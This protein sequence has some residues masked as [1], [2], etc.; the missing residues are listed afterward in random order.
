MNSL[1]GK[2][3]TQKQ[4]LLSI[5]FQ[6]QL[7]KKNDLAT[8]LNPFRVKKNPKIQVK[9]MP[10]LELLLKNEQKY[11]KKFDSKLSKVILSK[12]QVSRKQETLAERWNLIEKNKKI[13]EKEDWENIK[14]N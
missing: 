9:K 11:L 3:D 8:L 12:K 2:N 10:P 7:V 5:A 6:E 1:R 13:L 14:L 4:T